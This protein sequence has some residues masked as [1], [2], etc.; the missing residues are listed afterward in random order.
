MSHIPANNANEQAAVRLPAAKPNIPDMPPIVCPRSPPPVPPDLCRPTTESFPSPN[1]PEFEE[2]ATLH[3]VVVEDDEESPIPADWDDTDT[4]DAF[5]VAEHSHRPM[6]DELEHK[7]FLQTLSDDF[8]RLYFAQWREELCQQRRRGNASLTMDTVQR[9]E[10]EFLQKQLD[11]ER[12]QRIEWLNLVRE[13]QKLLD[14]TMASLVDALDA[15]SDQNNALTTR[16]ARL[17]DAINQS[18]TPCSSCPGSRTASRSNSLRNSQS[19]L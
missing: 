1:C 18:L 13:K 2:D 4:H 11:D 19:D 17:Q 9:R 8:K 10:I 5:I 16:V 14:E 6:V 3:I 12:Q 7:Q 15:V